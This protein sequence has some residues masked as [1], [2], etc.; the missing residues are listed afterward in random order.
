MITSEKEIRIPVSGKASMN[1]IISSPVRPDK[2]QIRGDFAICK[3]EYSDLGISA[4]IESLQCLNITN[5][6]ILNWD[7]HFNSFC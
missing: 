5:L 7:Y 3:T 2:K 4:Y 6:A 1:I